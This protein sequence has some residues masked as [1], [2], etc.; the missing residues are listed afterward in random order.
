MAKTKAVKATETTTSPAIVSAGN[1]QS[2]P[3]DQIDCDHDWNIRSG[4][5]QLD[6][7]NPNDT[8]PAGSSV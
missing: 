8:N 4:Q 6:G 2:V 5:F 3:M 1:F 7:E